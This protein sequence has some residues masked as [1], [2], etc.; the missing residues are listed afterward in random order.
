MPKLPPPPRTAQK[1][2]GSEV[3]LTVDQ[4]AVGRDEVDLQ[5]AVDRHAVLPGQPADAAAEGQA[6]EADGASVA[7]RRR[8]PV[9][10]RGPRVLAGRRAALGGTDLAHRVDVDRAQGAEIDQHPAV[11][12]RVP[13]DAVAAA[14]DGD[15]EVEI[16]SRDDRARDVD[17]RLGADDHRGPPVVV[18]VVRAARLVVAGIAVDQDATADRRTDRAQVGSGD[19]GT[20]GRAGSA[21]GS[22]LRVGGGGGGGE[23]RHRGRLL[24]R[25]GGSCRSG[26][27]VT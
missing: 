18:G 23:V 12:R 5:Q 9:L 21:G 25:S 20:R 19:G 22:G 16:A 3:S 10:V 14:A 6:P 24:G 27:S 7:E 13:G 2:S 1:R 26:R 8:E 15:L 4:V 17:G 11:A